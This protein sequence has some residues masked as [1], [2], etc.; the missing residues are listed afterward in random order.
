MILWAIVVAA[1]TGM[2]VT[3][4]G[5]GVTIGVALWLAVLLLVLPTIFL[6]LYLIEFILLIRHAKRANGSVP[7][8][9][10]KV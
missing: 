5:S 6:V 1:A 9:Y 7:S 10:V 8:E 2:V 3:G 4:G